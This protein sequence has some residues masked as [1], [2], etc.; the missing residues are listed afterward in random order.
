[1]LTKELS[2]WLQIK[3]KKSLLIC[4][5]NFE[6]SKFHDANISKIEKILK[7]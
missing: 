5:Y 4:N 3:G 6:P 2:Q 1:M 7:F